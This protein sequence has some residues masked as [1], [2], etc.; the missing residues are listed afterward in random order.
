MEVFTEETIGAL[1]TLVES[2]KGIKQREEFHPEVDLFSHS[3]QTMNCAFRESDDVE[4]IIAAMVH[5]VGKKICVE[6]SERYG[7]ETAAHDILFPLVSPKTLWLVEN[8]M[9][10]WTYILGDMKKLSK[11]KDLVNHPW[12]YE[13]TQLARF[14]KRG[15]RP[16]NKI[17]YDRQKVM[18]R[19]NKKTELH[20]RQLEGLCMEAFGK[21]GKIHSLEDK[22]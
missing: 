22:E 17:N 18:D 19:L 5:D 10:F 8:H 7:H 2:T 13:L 21:S 14:D 1:L 9:R 6:D 11:V 20:F 4:L 12:F 16:L 15:R 3:I